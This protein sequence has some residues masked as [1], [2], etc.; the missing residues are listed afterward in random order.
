[1]LAIASLAYDVATCA[2]TRPRRVC[3]H[4]PRRGLSAALPLLAF[5]TGIEVVSPVVLRDE[6][7][8]TAREIATMYTSG[9]KG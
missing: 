1:M 7:T 2:L 6:L 5:G 4:P 3:Q 8:R 9:I